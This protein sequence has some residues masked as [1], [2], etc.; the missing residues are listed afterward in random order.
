LLSSEFIPAFCKDLAVYSF[1]D[2]ISFVESRSLNT[3]G[4]KGGGA[5]ETGIFGML[6]TELGPN[7]FPP[8]MLT[9]KMKTKGLEVPRK[10]ARP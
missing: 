7:G 5:G 8:P 4:Q 1:F 6:V 3:Q 10:E 9:Q 2:E